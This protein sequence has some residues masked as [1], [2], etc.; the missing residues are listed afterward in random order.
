L[1]AEAGGILEVSSTQLRAMV[2]GA[3]GFI[4]LHLTAELVRKGWEV[5][6][7]VRSGSEDRAPDWGPAVRTLPIDEAD[8]S[9]DRMREEISQCSVI[10]DL[11]GSSGAVA[12]NRAP[13]ASLEANC[14][15]QLS[16]LDSCTAAGNRPRIVF[17]SSRLVYGETG[18]DPVSEDHTVSP[19]SIYAAHKLCVENY[20]Q[21]YSRLGYITH[22]ICR[23]SNVYGF[24]ASHGPQGYRV[25]NAFIR[26]G[27][28]GEAIT[29]YGDGQQ[30]RDLIY[31][32]DLVDM[33]LAA[34][35]SEAG[36]N[37]VFNIGSGVSASMYEAAS[38]I[39]ELTSAQPIRFAPWPPEYRLVESGDYVA[40][41]SKAQRLLDISCRFDL[42]AGIS[43][44]IELYRQRASAVSRPA[45]TH[46]SMAAKVS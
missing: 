17:S 23:I 37:Q 9:S 32:T 12:S 2:W 38:L 16:F 4:G 15:A 36:C 43:E 45:A 29:L 18:T 20:L 11:A 21:I 28:L 34:G 14:R 27:L 6:A 7:V 19:Q 26:T 30:L 33:L 41:I 3:H 22:T 10:Y 42:L 1:V 44:T 46:M 5:T 40:D 24:D 31:I 35:V 39:R 25:M 13:L 8:L